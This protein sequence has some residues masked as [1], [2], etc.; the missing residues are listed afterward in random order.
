S[1]TNSL[2]SPGSGVFVQTPDNRVGGTNPSSRNLVSG[3]GAVGIEIFESF[4]SNNVVQG[5]FIG[6][7]RTGTK[8]IGNTD[9]AL[10]V[11]M[12]ASAAT[13]G[14]EVPGAGNVI[15][16]NLNRGITLD[17]SDNLVQGNFIGTTVTGQPLGN[18]R[19]GVEI[20]GAR[21]FV[22]G[23]RNGARNVIA[24]NGVN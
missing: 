5:N 18:A 17:G 13:I 6:T 20:G 4:A 7:D 8:A 23:T 2:G 9:R 21:N 19:T 10:V 22:G 1:G 11:N 16:G 14:G 15:S 24:F 3:K 12:N